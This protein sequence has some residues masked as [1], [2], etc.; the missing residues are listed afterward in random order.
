M[1]DTATRTGIV[2]VFCETV[3][4]LGYRAGVY[5]NKTWMTKY[6]NMSEL[7]PYTKWLAQYRAAGPTY[8]GEYSIWQ[9]SSGGRVDGITGRV[10]L[11]IYLR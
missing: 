6:L 2:K 1:L 10:D 9:Y 7:A 4:S 8:D 11:D 5:A 3:E